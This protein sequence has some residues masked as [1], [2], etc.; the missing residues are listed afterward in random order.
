MRLLSL[1]AFG[2]FIMWSRYNHANGLVRAHLQLDTPDS[3]NRVY[4][5]LE[6]LQIE[7]SND[8]E[9]VPVTILRLEAFC[10]DEQPDYEKYSECE[11]P[12]VLTTPTLIPPG[13]RTLI[14]AMDVTE[15]WLS[16]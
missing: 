3:R 8:Q 4:D 9:A 10:R 15:E 16:V 1:H 11:Q 7:I 14:Q 6:S 13:L 12:A 2:M 5:G